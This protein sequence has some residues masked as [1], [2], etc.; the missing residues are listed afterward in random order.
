MEAT[1]WWHEILGK[2]AVT[3]W[4]AGAGM[5]ALPAIF[6][7]MSPRQR[8]KAL[9]RNE[10]AHAKSKLQARERALARATVAARA[11]KLE[12]RESRVA[13]M[14]ASVARTREAHAAR[15]AERD[16][17]AREAALKAAKLQAQKQLMNAGGS[18]YGTR[19]AFDRL[20]ASTQH[21]RR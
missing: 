12:S 6:R 19:T 13:R 7:G 3:Q 1:V 14:T 15:E 5:W 2:I 11:T 4:S 20:Y 18:V 8:E 17:K 16:T 9:F 10:I 21:G